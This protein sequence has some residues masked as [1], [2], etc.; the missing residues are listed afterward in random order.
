MAPR[1]EFPPF[2][3]AEEVALALDAAELPER[4]Q[5]LELRVAELERR[6]AAAESHRTSSLLGRFLRRDRIAG[7]AL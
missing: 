4:R 1:P 5:R 2:G 6:L 7:G 3:P